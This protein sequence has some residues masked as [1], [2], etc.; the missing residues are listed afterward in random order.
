MLV[1]DDL[2][3]DQPSKWFQE[4]LFHILDYRFGEM[5]P[6]II[7]TSLTPKELQVHVGDKTLKRI[8]ENAD[9]GNNLYKLKTNSYRKNVS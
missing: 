9:K 3:T 7:T 6:T 5:L 1:L 2:G 8:I 4:R